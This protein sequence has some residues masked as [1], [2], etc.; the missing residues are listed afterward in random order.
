MSLAKTG[1]LKPVKQ[2]VNTP[3]PVVDVSLKDDG[4]DDFEDKEMDNDDDVKTDEQTTDDWKHE[5]QGKNVEET[6]VDDGI[7]DQSTQGS[8]EKE[9]NG[10]TEDS[11]MNGKKGSLLMMDSN[12]QVQVKV[13]NIVP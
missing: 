5:E 4:D 11:V 1:R 7:N 9:Q 3:K 2:Y 10:K 12:C 8:D 13:Y 6:K